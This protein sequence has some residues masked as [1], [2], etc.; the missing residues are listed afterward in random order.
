MFTMRTS[1]ITWQEVVAVVAG[2]TVAVAAYVGT[3]AVL[4]GPMARAITHLA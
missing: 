4:F 2:A 1:P 3:L